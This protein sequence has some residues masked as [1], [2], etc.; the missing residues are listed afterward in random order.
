MSAVSGWSANTKQPSPKQPD[1]HTFTEHQA[2]EQTQYACYAKQQ[3]HARAP[4]MSARAKC[5]LLSAIKHL[6]LQCHSRTTQTVHHITEESG[7]SDRSPT[8]DFLIQHTGLTT[9]LT[10]VV[11]AAVPSFDFGITP[12]SSETIQE[13]DMWRT[14]LHVLAFEGLSHLVQAIS[15]RR[16]DVILGE[17]YVKLAV[18]LVMKK[19]GVRT[20]KWMT[21]LEIL[22]LMQLQGQHQLNCSSKAPSRTSLGRTGLVCR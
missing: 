6:L 19:K 18:Q 16:S 1:I 7:S 4:A 13:T 14:E 12:P 8:L 15:A 17:R 11:M 20:F 2:L 22:K 3:V 10:E 21:E 9:L 5:K